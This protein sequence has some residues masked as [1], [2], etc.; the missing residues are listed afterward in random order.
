MHVLDHGPLDALR[1]RRRGQGAVVAPVVGEVDAGEERA[2]AD[3]LLITGAVSLASI[4]VALNEWV[5]PVAAGLSIEEHTDDGTQEDVAVGVLG[6]LDVMHQVH[7]EIVELA[8]D[9]VLRRCVEVELQRGEERLACVWERDLEL[10]GLL[11]SL[12]SRVASE[13]HSHGRGLLDI[14]L[15]S[16]GREVIV[17]IADEV[18]FVVGFSVDE[19]NGGL[20]DSLGAEGVLSVMDGA[21]VG[22]KQLVVVVRAT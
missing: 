13:V 5:V 7:L 21:P 15:D 8:L 2:E 11:S 19:V 6:A 12:R 10:S 4:K 1:A 3:V 17:V 9:G 16:K 22:A 14:R 20:L 18:H